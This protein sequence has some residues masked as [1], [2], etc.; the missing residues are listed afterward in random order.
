[1]TAQPHDVW[2]TWASE[3]N[4]VSKE[5]VWLTWAS[6]VNQVSKETCFLGL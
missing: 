6:E 3:V 2:L 4:Q 1:M 5:D